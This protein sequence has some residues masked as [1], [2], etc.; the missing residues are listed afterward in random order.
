MSVRYTRRALLQL[1]DIFAYIA[2]DKPRAAHDVHLKIRRMIDS[3]AG[4]PFIGRATDM[5]GVRVLTIARYPY[6]PRL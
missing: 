5:P 4:F 3:L 2:A 1:N 6:L